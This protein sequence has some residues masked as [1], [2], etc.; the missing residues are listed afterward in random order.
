MVSGRENVFLGDNVN[1][2]WGNTIYAVNAKFV[3]KNN[4]G[5]AVG[6]TVVTGNHQRVKGLP[7]KKTIIGRK[8]DIEKDIVVE[9]DVWLAANV[10]LLSGAHVGRGATV[11]AGSVCFKS[12]PPY[13]VVMGNP[14]KI[15]GFNF[16]PEETI[17]HEKELYPEEERI[18]FE[19]LEKNYK[20]FFLDRHDE[21]RKFLK[22]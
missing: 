11:G 16:T 18:P 7:I 10:T 4:S 3:M 6:L 9:E 22:L 1:I 12:I 14:A 20:N 19:I 13:A 21:I 8:H 2:D 5:A 17:E 15:V